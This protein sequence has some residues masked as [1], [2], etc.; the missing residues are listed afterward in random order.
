MI[1]AWY[2]LVTFL[3]QAVLTVIALKILADDHRLNVKA[4]SARNPQDLKMLTAPDRRDPGLARR[5]RVPEQ[6]GQFSESKPRVLG[7]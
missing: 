5:P 4:L 3:A 6:E 7:L 1:P 2:L